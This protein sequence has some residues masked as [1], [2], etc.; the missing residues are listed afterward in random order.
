[1]GRG[2]KK[3]KDMVES[4]LHSTVIAWFFHSRQPEEP[5]GSGQGRSRKASEEVTITQING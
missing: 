1:M 3:E 4:M 5:L 2:Q